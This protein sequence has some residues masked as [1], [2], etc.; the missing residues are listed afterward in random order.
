MTDLGTFACAAGGS[1]NKSLQ[2]VGTDGCVTP[3]LAFL[4]E[5]GG[6]IVDLNTLVPPNSGLQLSEAHQINDR[7]EIAIGALDANG[8]NHSVLLIPCDENHPGVEGCDYGM[9]DAAALQP[10]AAP[11]TQH[12]VHGTPRS[13]MPA[14]MLN[15]F[16]SR[17]GQRTPV[18]ATVPA[19]AAEQTSPANTDSVDVEGEQLLG[20]LA[21][22]YKGYCAVSGSKLT[23]FCTAFYYYACAAKASTAC[24]SG[25]TAIKPGYFQCSNRNS[26]YVDLG[27]SCSFN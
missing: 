27:R 25:Q 26:R 19:P 10:S 18:S 3:N 13:R 1:V 14:G 24:P 4:W 15:R 6:P 5:D 8:N 9:V 16:R 12:P 22:R 23:G 11:A 21:G 2:V 17:W 20:P 7:G